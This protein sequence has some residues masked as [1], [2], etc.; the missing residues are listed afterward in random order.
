MERHAKRAKNMIWGGGWKILKYFEYGK[1]K[2]IKA[3]I[4]N[5]YIICKRVYLTHLLALCACFIKVKRQVTHQRN[6]NSFQTFNY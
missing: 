1:G 6:Y 3:K 4:K 2:K 5:K